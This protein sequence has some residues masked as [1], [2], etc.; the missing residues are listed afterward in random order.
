MSNELSKL[1]SLPSKKALLRATV[2]AIPHAGGALDHLL[3]DRADEI[4]LNN[5]E[6]AIAAIHKRVEE[7]G[8][9]AI[10]ADWF[11]STEALALFRNMADKVQFEPDSKKVHTLAKFVATAGSNEFANDRR[12]LSVFDHVSS[13]SFVQMKLLSILGSM[14]PTQKE[15]SGGDG[16]ISLT[17][18][19]LWISDIVKILGQNAN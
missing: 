12:K 14:N 10:D 15:F 3:F 1:S 16:S 6:Q 17:A 13:L 11:D 18:S 19:G 7:L 4:R 8:E 2:A 5:I 9:S